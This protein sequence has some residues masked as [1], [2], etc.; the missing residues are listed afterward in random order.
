MIDLK[1][2]LAQTEAYLHKLPPAPP[3]L[4]VPS[5]A[6]LAG[7]IDHTALKAE[8]TASQVMKLCQE[9]RQHKFATVCVNP[10]YVPL[11]AGVLRGSEV[12]ICSVIS[13]P[14]GAHLPSF[15]A[16]EAK[17]AIDAGATEID[18]VVNIGALK[19][20]A[21]EL[22]YEDV[23][24]VV[25]ASHAHEV[26]VKVILEMCYLNQR[27]KIAGCLISK[28][29]GADFVKTSTGFG[30]SGAT[31]EDV[32][33]MRSVVGAQV[34]VKAAGGIRSLAD[35]LAMIQAGANRLGASAGISILQEAGV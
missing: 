17:M 13:F 14:L 25:E 24:A 5:G 29:A 18:M 34:G 28:A 26:H 32:S 35:A 21:L 11:A 6:E 15:K 12:G 7:W 22:V 31:V 1:E 4:A 2:I 19:A 33:L 20:D 9:A 16:V 8:T 3:A 10:G 23:R 30:P 27:E